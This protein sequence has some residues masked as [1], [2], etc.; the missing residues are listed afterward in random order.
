MVVSRKIMKATF[1]N[2]A[3]AIF[4]TFELHLTRRNFF[5]SLKRNL[6]SIILPEEELTQ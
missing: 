3:V 2:I 1:I 5:A 4:N 6:S